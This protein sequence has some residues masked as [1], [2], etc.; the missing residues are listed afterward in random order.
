MSSE[1]LAVGSQQLAVGS[2]QL[3]VGGRQYSV[4]SI[5][6]AVYNGL[7]AKEG[8]NSMRKIIHFP[9]GAKCR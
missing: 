6:C 1:Q 8:L 4:N 7:V 9:I 2:R 3:E 5:L